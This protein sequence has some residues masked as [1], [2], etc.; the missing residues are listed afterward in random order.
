M[1]IIATI[2]NTANDDSHYCDGLGII[3][4]NNNGNNSWLITF[5]K[6]GG[7]L[8]GL[9]AQPNGNSVTY[10]TTSDT[11]LKTNIVDSK[12]GLNTVMNIQV[13]DYNFKNDLD[14]EQNGFLAQQL[15][16]Y[17]P[18]AVCEGGDDPT[19]RPWMV[20]YGRVTRYLLKPFRNNRSKSKR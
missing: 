16:E 19:E 13:K 3:A 15:A 17:Y 9:I 20:D 6:P 5:R 11:R 2:E 1:T 18:F 8:L 12:Y 4:G 7:T 14:N 10:N